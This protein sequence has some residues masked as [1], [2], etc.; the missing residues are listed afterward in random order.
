MTR[1]IFD[2]EC[3]LKTIKNTMAANLNNEILLIDTE[4]GD[5]ILDAIPDEAWYFQQLG[6]EIF[7][8]PVFVVW[9][10]Y[11][12][13]DLSDSTYGNSIKKIEI[14]FEVVLIDDGSENSENIH[15]KLLR[16]TRALEQSINK[17]FSKA[18]SGLKFKIKDLTPTQFDVNNKMLRSAGI[19]VE[20]AISTN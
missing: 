10:T 7:S 12:N 15:Y 9:G 8:Y 20:A 6:E 1:K 18:V 14:Y 5:Y 2:I 13:P 11:G 19:T 3:L 17:N 16:Y 4:K